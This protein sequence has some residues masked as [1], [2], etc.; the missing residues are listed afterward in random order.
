MSGMDRPKDVGELREAVDALHK[1]VHDTLEQ[2]E[3]VVDVLRRSRDG[4]IDENSDLRAKLEQ[5]REARKEEADEP[6]GWKLNL[7]SRCGGA[8]L[9]PWEDGPPKVFNWCGEMYDRCGVG[10]NRTARYLRRD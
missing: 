7:Y 4:L 2:N 5:E 3:R 9:F 10:C 6:K 8:K 1:H